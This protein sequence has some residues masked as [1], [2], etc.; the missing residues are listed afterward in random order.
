MT[1][2]ILAFSISA[3]QYIYTYNARIPIYIV[4]KD[5]M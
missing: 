4:Y 1:M 5:T 2:N 3:F